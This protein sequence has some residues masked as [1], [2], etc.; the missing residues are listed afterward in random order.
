MNPLLFLS[1][2]KRKI[3]MLFVLSLPF[4]KAAMQIRFSAFL[5]GNRVS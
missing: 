5:S 1:P 4:W 2:A 3:K